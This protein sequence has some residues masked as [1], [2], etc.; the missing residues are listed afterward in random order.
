[1]GPSL[2]GVLA[3]LQAF[4]P[5]GLRAYA[6]GIEPRYAGV[7]GSLRE[8]TRLRR[9]GEALARAIEEGRPVRLL[10]ARPGEPRRRWWR[11][12]PYFLG[13]E[14]GSC[15]LLGRD[16]ERGA[17][18]V[19]PLQAVETVRA[20]RGAFQLPLGLDLEG[21]LAERLRRAG[22]AGWSVRLRFKKG[23]S[24]AGV[25]AFLA[26]A[27]GAAQRTGGRGD[28]ELTVRTSDLLGLRRWLVGFGPEAE[29]LAPREL[30][31]AV[32]QDLE[33]ALGRYK[34]SGRRPEG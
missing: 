7:I 5:A 22:G 27:F 31:M 34:K 30:R 23:A 33:A 8:Q 3:R 10:A 6:E 2:G 24:L 9:V 15:Y 11:V 28:G 29:V 18:E 13:F 17:I 26:E 20:G 25:A 12:D 14:G 32:A 16:A 4:V 21:A 1:M 19:W